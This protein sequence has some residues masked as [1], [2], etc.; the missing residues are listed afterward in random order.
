MSVELDGGGEVE[1][2]GEAVA[3]EVS[4]DLGGAVARVAGCRAAGGVELRDRSRA[5]R[6]PAGADVL[7]GACVVFIVRPCGHESLGV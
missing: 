1:L 6:R 5:D 3:G 4:D 2:A 7:W